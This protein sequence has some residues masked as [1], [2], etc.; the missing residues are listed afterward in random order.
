MLGSRLVGLIERHSN[1]L[2]DGLAHKLCNSSRTNDFRNIPH[3]E[4]TK[5]AHE[6]YSNLSDWL[7]TKTES[8]IELRYTAIGARRASQGV[9][10]AQLVWAM[11]MSKE[12]LWGFLQREG[13]VTGPVELFGELEL[14]QFL[15]Q[16]FDRAMYY[17]VVGY[18]E[19][20]MRKAA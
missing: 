12:H 14:L 10:L 13:F 1:E 9:A 6:I 2:A 11:L 19:R 5:A 8:D 4:L 3:D 15:D 17:A 7:L 16:F 18:G 20:A